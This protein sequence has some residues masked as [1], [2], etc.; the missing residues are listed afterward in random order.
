MKKQ[1]NKHLGDF[2]MSPA[3]ITAVG[4]SGLGLGL[5]PA[6]EHKLV[7]IGYWDLFVRVYRQF[8]VIWQERPV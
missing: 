8:P 4:C 2:T 3:E 1:P 6:T 7:V 5:E